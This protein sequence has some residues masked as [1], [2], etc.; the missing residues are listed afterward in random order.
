MPPLRSTYYRC[1]YDR[2]VD[3]PAHGNGTF[4]WWSPKR[5]APSGPPVFDAF[6]VFRLAVASWR[7]NTR[8]ED[9][10]NSLE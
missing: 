1:S 4:H 7:A 6:S 5:A 8:N 9:L 3:Y 2:R 10:E